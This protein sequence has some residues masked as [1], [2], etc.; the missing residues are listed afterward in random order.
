[1]S[2]A[3]R[4]EQPPGP[5][6]ESTP[7]CPLFPKNGAVPAGEKAGVP[8]PLR[9]FIAFAA[10]NMTLAEQAQIQYRVSFSR[11]WQKR[12]PPFLLS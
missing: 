4:Q 2:M 1:M 6:I 8:R 12:G 9:V 7:K 5:A 10:G 11:N 3:D